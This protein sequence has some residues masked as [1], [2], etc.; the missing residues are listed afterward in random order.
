MKDLNQFMNDDKSSKPL[1]KDAGADDEK[2][3]ALVSEYKIQRRHLSPKESMEKLEQIFDLGIN[4]DVSE[5]V[6]LG[7]AYL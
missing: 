4:G 6:K 7:A 5:K 2:Y 1:A 3:M